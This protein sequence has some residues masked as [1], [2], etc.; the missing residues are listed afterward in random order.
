MTELIEMIED[1]EM[2]DALDPVAKE[3][4]L[5]RLLTKYKTRFADAEAD[6]E[7]QADLFDYPCPS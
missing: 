4:H 7:R 2:L 1:L 3:A 6:L 5:E